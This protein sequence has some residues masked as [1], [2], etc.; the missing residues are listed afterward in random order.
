MAK[1]QISTKEIAGNTDDISLALNVQESTNIFKSIPRRHKK[2]RPISRGTYERSRLSIV[3]QLDMKDPVIRNIPRA[4]VIFYSFI[5]DKLHMCFGRDR[6]SG[7]ITDY[8]GTRI[9]KLNETSVQCAVREGN[10]ES[11]YAFSKINIDQVQGFSC[12][13]SSKMLII[14]IPVAS[15]NNDIDIR[16]ITRQ[17]FDEA[18]FLNY[19]QRKDRRYNEISEIVWLDE[20]QI[21]NLFSKFP[22]I[23]MYA[24]VRRFIYSCNQL[25]QNINTLKSVLKGIITGAS[26]NYDVDYLFQMI[27]IK[28]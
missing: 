20:S 5:N 14:F 12:L 1:S 10:E 18:R 28:F 2:Q 6:I 9:V 3:Y 21:D 24:K 19:N 15:P 23:Q 22:T 25:S 13:Y 8:G 7:D 27:S 26:Q 16:D 11:R 4:G 17:N